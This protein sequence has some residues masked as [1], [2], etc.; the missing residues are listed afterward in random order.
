MTSH[1][2]YILLIL[3]F[4]IFTVSSI[5][6]VLAHDH[7]IN[8]IDANYPPFS[9]IDEHGH[10]SGF[11]IE[12]M[13]WIAKS[14][15]FTI[16]HRPIDWDGILPALLSKKIDMICSGMSISPERAQVVLFTK[17]YWSTKKVLISCKNSPLI[18]SDLYS[19]KLRIGVQRGTNEAEKLQNDAQQKKYPYELRF[20]DSAALAIE[21]LLNGRIH[22]IVLDNTLADDALCHGKPIKKI[23]F[24]E[25]HDV[26]A[27]AL[28]KNDQAL[29]KRIEKGYELLQED[30]FWK[31]LQKKYFLQS[32]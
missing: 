13:N 30:P 17:P 25:E 24:L 31:E 29:A 28:R 2:K 20:Y 21:D 6:P 23:G 14:M 10:P 15:N 8:G 16:E 12:S 19:K 27:V 32:Q 5:L 26:F 9:F 4:L 11:D 3:S 18:T 7:Y 22:A 1:K